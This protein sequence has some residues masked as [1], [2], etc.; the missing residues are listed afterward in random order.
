MDLNSA[1]EIEASNPLK[2]KLTSVI[3]NDV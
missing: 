2:I 3:L 1:A